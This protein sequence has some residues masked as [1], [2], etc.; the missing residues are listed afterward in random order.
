[1][2]IKVYAS[3]LEGGDSSEGTFPLQA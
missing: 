2:P 3:S 1:R